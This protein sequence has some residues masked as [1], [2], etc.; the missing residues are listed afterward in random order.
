MRL[1]KCFSLIA[2]VAGPVFARAPQPLTWIRSAVFSPNGKRVAT[3]GDE[4]ILRLYD[5]ATGKILKSVRTSTVKDMHVTQI[6]YSPDG[7]MIASTGSDGKIRLWA[8]D[9]LAPVRSWGAGTSYVSGIA[10]SGSGK[11]LATSGYDNAARLWDPAKGKMIRRLSGLESDAYAVAMSRDGKLVAS[12]GPD[13]TCRIW[14]A[15]DGKLVRTLKPG[16]VMSIAFSPDGK[17]LVT[18]GKD[19][20]YYLYEVGTGKLML[21]QTTD[22]GKHITGLAFSPDSTKLAI[23]DYAN[24]AIVI[25]LTGELQNVFVG[26]TENVSSVEFSPD[27]KYLLTASFDS[28]ARLWDLASGECVRIFHR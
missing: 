28:T 9:T 20:K 22:S 8:A 27:G 23:G 7:R 1:W 5:A 16:Q 19:S 11:T 25:D 2:I 15:S 14:S 12:G 21:S 18:D 24:Q 10:W 13:G 26:H 4:G 3:A 17:Y 6:A